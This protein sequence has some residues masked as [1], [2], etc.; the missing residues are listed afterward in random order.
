MESAQRIKH[1]SPDSSLE[2]QVRASSTAGLMRMESTYSEPSE[3]YGTYPL[4]HR[5]SDKNI[6]HLVLKIGVGLI[7][8]SIRNKKATFTFI[9]PNQL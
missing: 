2:I 7:L 8:T 6:D 5:G 4:V 3:G 1:F 9:S